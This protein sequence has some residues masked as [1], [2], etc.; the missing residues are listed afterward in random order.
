MGHASPDP[1]D[2]YIRI[3]KLLD[4]YH[5]EERGRA[6]IL[7]IV[8]HL[9]SKAYAGCPVCEAARWEAIQDL[10]RQSLTDWHPET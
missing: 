6:R 1:L 9:A 10:D 5:V 2:E 7:Q 8:A 4:L 3:E